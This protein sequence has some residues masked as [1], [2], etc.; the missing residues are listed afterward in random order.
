MTGSAGL[1]SD[2][3]MENEATTVARTASVTR[4][5]PDLMTGM[6]KFLRNGRCHAPGPGADFPGLIKSRYASTITEGCLRYNLVKVS[7]W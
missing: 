5:L 6:R 2:C 3:N 1:T 4:G 7:R